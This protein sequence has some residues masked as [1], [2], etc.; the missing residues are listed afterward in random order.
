MKPSVPSILKGLPVS[1][2]VPLLS[3]R[4]DAETPRRGANSHRRVSVSLPL[5]VPVIGMLT[6]L[7]VLGASGPLFAQD[8]K[9]D[10]GT[11]AQREA[12]QQLY[13]QKCA[14]CHGDTGDGQG[15]AAPFFTPAPRDFTSGIFKFRTT[16]SGELPT[17]DDL[18]RSIRDGMPY[19]GMPAWPSLSEAEIQNLV[20]VLKSFNHFFADETYGVP[21]QIEI[22]RAPRYNEANLER[23]RVVFEE[24]QCA[25][26]HGDQGRGNGKSA[27]TLEDQWGFAIRPADLTKRWTFRNGQSREDIYRTFTTGLDGSPMPSYDMP[28]EDRWALVD[29]VWSLSRSDADYATMVTATGVEGA[30]DLSRGAALFDEATP[31][32]FSVVGQVIEPGRAFYPGVNGIEVRAVYNRDEVALLLSWHDMTAETTGSN[33]PTLPAPDDPRADTTGGAFSDAV[34]VLLP[35]WMPEGVEKPYF[36]FGDKKNPMAVWFADLASEAPQAFVGRG[37]DALEPAEHTLEMTAGYDDGVWTVLF[38]R[39]RVEED[40]LTFEE[41]TFVPIAFTVWDGFNRERGNKRGLTSWYALYLSP[42]ETQSA[43][44]PMAKWGL[45][46]LLLELAVVG[47]VRRRHK[48]RLVTA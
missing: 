41:G 19:T 27:P 5:R 11:D 17:D 36:L 45:L 14:Q 32:Y 47:L 21:E 33:S 44:L 46:T 6:L 20:Y 43:A 48:R 7:I 1:P 8:Q 35:A 24:N 39:K 10:L 37:R 38:K 4:G 23:G 3:R 34:A 28:E 40:G 16:A 25:D 9:P 13:L 31:A 12:G 15:V 22:P 42:L 2:A 18:K 29:Y 30:L 26:C